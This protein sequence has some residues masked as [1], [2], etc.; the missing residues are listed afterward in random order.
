M[1]IEHTFRIP[2][3][4]F[5]YPYFTLNV[6]N[7]G[8][9]WNASAT[10]ASGITI[11][12]IDWYINGVL[13]GSGSGVTIPSQPANSILLTEA[14]DSRGLKMRHI[15]Y[16]DNSDLYFELEGGG[17]YWNVEGGGEYFEL[18]VDVL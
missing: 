1:A 10:T 12:D 18:E 5:V 8:S 6:T 16:L 14:I 3:E 2:P 7:S 9:D 17:T 13:F 15:Q 4:E 11:T